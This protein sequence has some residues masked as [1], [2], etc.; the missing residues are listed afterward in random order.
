MKKLKVNRN[1]KIF[2]ACP[3]NTATGGPELLHQLVY[4]LNNLGLNSYMFYYSKSKKNPVHAAYEEYKNPYV[5]SIEDNK[6]NV[7]IVPETRTRLIYDYDQIQKVIWWLSLDNYYEVIGQYN[8]LKKIKKILLQ[9]V[10][11]LRVY[12]FENNNIFH[13]VQS[14]Y[15]KQHLEVKNISKIFYLSDYLNDI[16][17]EQQLKKIKI[18]KE[19]IVL[20]NPEKGYE[21]TSKLINKSDDIKFIPIENMTRNEVANILSRAKVYID[22]GHHPG[23]DRLPREAAISGCC[24]ITGKRGSAGYYEDVPIEDEFKFEDNSDNIR[25]ILKKIKNCFLEYDS[26]S[27]KFNF[28]RKKIK[29]EQDI[30]ISD[31]TDIFL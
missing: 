20:Y 4:E 29:N 24:V 8:F 12:R 17:I 26:N 25:R 5:L 1:T 3:G 2:V 10:G 6:E 31:I 13:L 30:F 28:Y 14:E 7:F 22:F 15:V 11:L 18:S 23:K 19:N 16:F 27:E 21:F 9:K